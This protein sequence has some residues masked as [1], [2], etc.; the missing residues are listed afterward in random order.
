[1]RYEDIIYELK[2]GVYDF[3]SESGTFP[4]LIYKGQLIILQ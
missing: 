1:M 3:A 2:D 4:V